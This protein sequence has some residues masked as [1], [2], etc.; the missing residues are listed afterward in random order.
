M[1]NQLDKV[2]LTCFVHSNRSI[3]PQV[4]SK[5]T[6]FFLF[7]RCT[8]QFGFVYL[9]RWVWMH[10]W[11]QKIEKAGWAGVDLSF[12]RLHL[13][14]KRGNDSHSLLLQL[15]N[16]CRH[17]YSTSTPNRMIL[18]N[19]LQAKHCGLYSR[20]NIFAIKDG[21]PFTLYFVF[22]PQIWSECVLEKQMWVDRSFVNMNRA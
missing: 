9:M 1:K 6:L 11:K 5:N 17:S 13:V 21:S 15:P 2:P 3:A 16:R 7:E 14:A 22:L 19:L 4:L 12:P 20:E 18:S 10:T 8:S